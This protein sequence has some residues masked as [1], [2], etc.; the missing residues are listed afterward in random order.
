MAKNCLSSPKKSVRT[1]SYPAAASNLSRCE[2]LMRSPR[3][4]PRRAHL[5]HFTICGGGEIRTHGALSG[6]CFPSMCNWPLCDSSLIHQYIF[7][8][9]EEVRFELTR[10]FRVGG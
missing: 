4:P 1:T 9:A 3:P 10:P 8:F 2:A 6:S 5:F 7:I